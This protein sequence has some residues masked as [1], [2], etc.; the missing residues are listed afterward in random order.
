M[1]ACGLEGQMTQDFVQEVVTKFRICQLT[2][3][4]IYPGTRYRCPLLPM[5]FHK[6]AEI[7]M[8]KEW[9]KITSEDV[10]TANHCTGTERQN[11]TG[12]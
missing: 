11:S 1:T 3:L 7:K 9:E 10:F 4:Q 5:S 2:R 12:K 8:A 6:Y